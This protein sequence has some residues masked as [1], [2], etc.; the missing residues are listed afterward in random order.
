MSV[1]SGIFSKKKFPQ[2]YATEDYLNRTPWPTRVTKDPKDK[3]FVLKKNLVH[4]SEN[5][6]S[7]IPDITDVQIL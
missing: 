4:N 1:I 6:F 2:N 5:F 7:K 3:N